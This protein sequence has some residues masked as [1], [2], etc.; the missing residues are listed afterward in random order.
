MVSLRPSP[1]IP[2]GRANRD[3]LPPPVA[4]QF[5]LA[6]KLPPFFEEDRLTVDAALE[7]LLPLALLAAPSRGRRPAHFPP[8]QP[9]VPRPCP[10]KT[11][12]SYPVSRDGASFRQRC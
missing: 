6:M 8:F 12:S 9:S 10:R 7:R 5:L 11:N 1:S 3:Q 4:R 2:S